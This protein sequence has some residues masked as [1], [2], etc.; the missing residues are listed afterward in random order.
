MLILG[1]IQ[2]FISAVVFW[3]RE[4]AHPSNRIL[5]FWL[6]IFALLF[7]GQLLPGGLVAY[8]R[9]GFI[10]FFMLSGPV[11][12]FYVRSLIG[13]DFH[14]Q[15][16]D[17]WHLLPF[18]A[19]AIFRLIYFPESVS[20]ETFEGSHV[21]TVIWAVII[22]IVVS[23]VLYWIATMMSLFRHQKNVLNFFS[24]RSEKRSL[25]WVPLFMLVTLVSH[26]LFFSGPFL[27]GAF[28]D[29]EIQ[30][31]WFQQFNM[32]LLGYLLLV[33]GLNQPVIFDW[34]IGRKTMALPE[35]PVSEKYVH[36]GLTSE[37]MEAL[38]NR[39]IDYLEKERPYTNPDYKL[40][41]MMQDLDSSQQ[42]LSQTINE[43]LGKNFYQ[44]I[45]EYRV[46]EFQRLL[47]E[48]DSSQFTIL[49][50]AYA[51]GFNSKS[52]FN[53]VFKEITGLTPSQYQR[54]DSEPVG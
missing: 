52:S 27:P 54:R 5:A 3:F 37:A 26:V 9:I 4:P 40:Q 11:L 7:L 31:F 53:R 33:F 42:Y 22:L 46:K 50:L 12:Y 8:T 39:L 17:V 35:D 28:M 18:V 13:A 36:S 51:A 38:A 23:V 14:F 43:Q 1:L 6:L 30:N 20:S 29:V 32:A 41:T 44:L 21:K 15:R 34:A 10:P 2:S 19:V 16:R 24:N 47:W 45:N 49:G 25:K 48:P